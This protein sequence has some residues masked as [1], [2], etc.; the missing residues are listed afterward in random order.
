MSPYSRH[1]KG[2]AIAESGALFALGLTL[3]SGPIHQSVRRFRDLPCHPRF[4]GD[5][6]VYLLRFGRL[7]VRPNT[8][9]PLLYDSNPL[10]QA[11]SS[12]FC[13]IFLGLTTPY[14]SITYYRGSEPCSRGNAAAVKLQGRR[15]PGGLPQAANSA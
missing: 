12:L 5:R 1:A 9:S 8:A 6:Y 15:P 14:K 2:P 4:P 11:D 3:S 10:L 7:P 13:G